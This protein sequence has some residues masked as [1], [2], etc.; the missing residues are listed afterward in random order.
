M[1]ALL[2][3]ISSVLLVTTLS[4]RAEVIFQKYSP[5]HYV[6]VIDEGGVRMLSFNGTRET[7]MSLANP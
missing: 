3:A 1:R 7:R 6:Q 5:Y 2:I 4:L